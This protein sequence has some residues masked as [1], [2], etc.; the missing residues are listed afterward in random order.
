MYSLEDRQRAVD[1]YIKYHRS[2][3]D[4]VRELGYPSKST[5]KHW[6]REF[7]GAGELHGGYIQNKARYTDEQKEAAIRHYL[8][9]GRSLTR[10]VG[11]LG[12]PSKQGLRLWLDELAPNERRICWSKTDQRRVEFTFEQKKNAVVDLCSRKALAREVARTH[13]TTRGQL[14]NWKKELL[15]KEGVPAM[16]EDEQRAVS[17][18]TDDLLAQIKELKETI[19]GL[20]DQ[21]GELKNQ[22]YRLKMEKDILD[23]TIEIVKKDQGADPLNLTNKEKAIVIGALRMKY[24]LC[25]LLDRLSMPKSSYF[26]QVNAQAAPDKYAYLREEVRRWFAESDSTYGYRRI[27]GRMTRGHGVVVS[28]KVVRGIMKEEGLVVFSKKRRRYNSY[29]GDITPEVKNLVD[30]NFQTDAPNKLWLTDLTEFHIPAGKVYLSPVLDCFD[31]MLVSWTISTSP[32]AELVNAMLDLAIGTLDEKEHPLVHSDQG[33][34]YRWPGWI[35]RMNSAGL[36]RSMSKK[37]CSPDNSACEGLFGRIKNEMFYYRSWKGVS[38]EGFIDRLNNYLH[39]YNRKRIKKSLGYLSP[40][41]YRQSLGLA[42]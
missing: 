12:Y 29:Q 2:A 25:D 33:R 10:T 8:E 4:T 21:K 42:A 31:G 41:E 5:L 11:A 39:W 36:I 37:G 35:D 22:V 6:H 26:Y 27:H 13:N 9:Y 1:L 28:E 7:I 16:P 20:N 24:P 40:V 34:H 23:A 17:D 30:R 15:G 38:I 19:S 14:Y 32:N 18:N 3:A